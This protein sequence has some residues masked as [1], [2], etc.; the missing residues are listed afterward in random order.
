MYGW[1]NPYDSWSNVEN[2]LF[3]D[4]CS[5][6]TN[7]NSSFEKKE[8]QD[9]IDLWYGKLYDIL[10]YLQGYTYSV[11]SIFLCPIHSKVIKS[12]LCYSTWPVMTSTK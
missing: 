12:A 5:W 1:N 8:I 9:Y 7:V 3:T 10:H 6:D 11:V 2:K 4:L